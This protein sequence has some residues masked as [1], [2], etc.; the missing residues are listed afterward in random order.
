MPSGDS[1]TGWAW[2]CDVVATYTVASSA[3]YKRFR[4]RNSKTKQMIAFLATPRGLRPIRE[5]HARKLL[6]K[7]GAWLKRL[8]YSRQIRDPSQAHA[9]RQLWKMA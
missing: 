8:A 9:A 3:P 4:R 6:G 2:D 1:S 7:D 5:A